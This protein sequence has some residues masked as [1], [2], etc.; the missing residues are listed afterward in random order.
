MNVDW[1]RVNLMLDEYV[2]AH[3][4]RE[5]EAINRLTGVRAALLRIDTTRTDAH[6]P[7]DEDRS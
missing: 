2:A 5:L 3:H 6:D 7:G 1:E 4:R